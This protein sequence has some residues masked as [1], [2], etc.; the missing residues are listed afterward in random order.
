[1]MG[2]KIVER[3]FRCYQVGLLSRHINFGQGFIHLR[4]FE[5]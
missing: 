5:F 1:M 3:P 2:L 4:H